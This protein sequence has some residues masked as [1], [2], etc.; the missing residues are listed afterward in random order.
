MT[1]QFVKL[2]PYIFSDR[3][4][5]LDKMEYLCCEGQTDNHTHTLSYHK[6]NPNIWI[7][8]LFHKGGCQY[9]IKYNFECKTVSFKF[10]IGNCCLDI[11]NNVSNF[12][13]NNKKQIKYWFRKEILPIH[14]AINENQIWSS[15][16]RILNEYLYN[17]ITG[18]IKDYLCYFD[19]CNC[20]KVISGQYNTCYTCYKSKFCFN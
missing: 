4:K 17:D 11:M 2:N 13:D 6:K 1:S 3:H 16:K 18:I 9:S 19:K 5:S 20:G 14:N 10:S 8:S 12:V 7:L 15:K